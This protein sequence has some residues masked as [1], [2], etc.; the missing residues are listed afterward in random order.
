LFDQGLAALALSREGCERGSGPSA[1]N[2][3]QNRG[4]SRS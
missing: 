3:L 4:R 1:L 2:R